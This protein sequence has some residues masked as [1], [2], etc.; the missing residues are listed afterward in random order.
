M[1]KRK[2]TKQQIA[3]AERGKKRA[4]AKQA[5]DAQKLAPVNAQRR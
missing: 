1:G 2:V 5:R 3:S 4:A